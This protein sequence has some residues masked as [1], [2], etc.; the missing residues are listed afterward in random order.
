MDNYCEH[1]FYGDGCP[2]CNNIGPYKI[3]KK[4]NESTIIE[5]DEETSIF[6]QKGEWKSLDYKVI[7][8][9]VKVPSVIACDREAIENYIDKHPEC[10]ID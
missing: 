5:W 8:L 3:E 9:K 4:D 10:Y 6:D 7:T 2:E 1:G